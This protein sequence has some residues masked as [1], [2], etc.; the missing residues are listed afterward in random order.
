MTIS[1]GK[2]FL[3]LLLTFFNFSVFAETVLDSRPV[4]VTLLRGDGV[5][6]E[7]VYTSRSELTNQVNLHDLKLKVDGVEYYPEISI[8]A[9]QD[10]VLGSSICRI[11]GFSKGV[12]G[13]A[14]VDK[15]INSFSM[16]SKGE[17][18]SLVNGGSSDRFVAATA[19][20]F[21][22]KAQ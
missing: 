5:E 16:N 20:V 13:P 21:C 6:A 19:Q 17:I 1:M 12:L 15:E 2:R 3:I 14:I 11:F 9:Y 4:D 8:S 18:T 10:E 7:L 22:E